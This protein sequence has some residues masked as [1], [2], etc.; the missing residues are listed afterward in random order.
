MTRFA[1]QFTN[2]SADFDFVNVGR[3]KENADMKMRKMVKFYFN[4]V[5]CKKIL[6]AGCH[7]TGYLHDVKEICEMDGAKDRLVLVETTPAE[8]GFAQLGLPIISFE[9]VFRSAPLGNEKTSPSTLR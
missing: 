1:E 3:G 4:N 5:Q 8:A 6:F 7:D 2:S 9:S